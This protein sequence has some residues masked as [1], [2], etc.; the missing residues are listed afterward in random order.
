MPGLSRTPDR[1]SRC[2][3]PFALLCLRAASLFVLL[4]RLAACAP[5]VGDESQEGTAA[6]GA[7]VDLQSIDFASGEVIELPAHWEFYWKR[8]I[9]P[10]A[11][12][13]A[14]LHPDALVEGMEPWTGMTLPDKGELPGDGFASY[15]MVLRLKPGEYGFRLTQQYTA[16]RMYIDGEPV[17]SVGEPGSTAYT[18]RSRRGL[19]TFYYT[20][21]KPE[22]EVLL[23]VANFAMFRGGLRTGSQ[24]A[25]AEAMIQ[26]DF[27]R[28]AIEIAVFGFLVAVVLYHLAFFFTQARQKSFLF[29]AILCASFAIRFPFLGENTVDLLY[30]ELS[31]EFELRLMAT[32]NMVSP[33]LVM[34]F[35]R[36]VFPD[37]VSQRTVFLYGILSGIFMLAH[38]PGTRTLSL[39]VFVL[40]LTVLGPVLLHAAYI[41]VSMALRGRESA[42]IMAC[43]VLAFTMLV[44]LAMLRSWQA[45]RASDFAI[46]GFAIFALFQSVA[47]GRLYRESLEAQVSLKRRLEQSREALRLQR[48]ELEINL[49][50]S[51]GGALTDLKIMTDRGLDQVR[52]E[53][54]FSARE[55]LESFS[56]RLRRTNLA[57]RG[58]LLFMEDMELA[59]REPL[60]GLHMMLL[61]RYSDAGREL[62][63]SVQEAGASVLHDAM[64]D[65]TWRF[66]FMQLARE[67]CTNDLK[68]GAGESSWEIG[69][70]EDGNS[71]GPLIR[72]NQRNKIRTDGDASNGFAGE[73]AR[74]AAER[75]AR[76]GG[77]LSVRIS[78]DEYVVQAYV[79]SA[80]PLENLSFP[81]P[82]ENP[83]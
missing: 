52:N 62:D 12:V 2:S 6:G 72:L 7:I 34:L 60:T 47:L 78:G 1:G 13:R 64:L 46:L 71:S 15:R 80:S 5:A 30:G 70:E 63:F 76:L 26:Y 66:E 38:I 69:R 28:K 27:R 79:R 56:E 18:T 45:L 31:W 83:D 39:A 41:T 4:M 8:F 14:P 65:D 22:T 33:L 61:R 59:S 77:S 73:R 32:I 37:S 16:V 43:G 21:V 25:S 57:F 11:R 82:A 44:A 74:R 9:N 17:A 10:D 50:D 67:I 36:S 54:G 75:A 48:K 42:I 19:R 35:M 53:A 55:H 40:A 68:Y 29:F 51:L 49:H 20:V 3:D 24:M 81:V 58:H 23:H